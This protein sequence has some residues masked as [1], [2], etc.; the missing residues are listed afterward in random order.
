MVGH[1]A[2]RNHSELPRFEPLQ[3]L[4]DK[5]ACLVIGAKKNSRRRFV[6]QVTKY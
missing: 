1:H 5:P 3:N 6:Q 4:R 2:V